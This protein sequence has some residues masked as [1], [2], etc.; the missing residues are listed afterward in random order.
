MRFKDLV[1]CSVE[2]LAFQTKAH[3]A[4]WG[5]GSESSWKFDQESG[6]LTWSF[7]QRVVMAPAG[8]VGTFNETEGSWLWS[9]ANSSISKT[10]KTAA[11]LAREHGKTNDFDSLIEPRYD[12]DVNEAW[13]LAAL[14]M[15]LSKHQGVYKIKEGIVHV[16][17]C[18]G[19]VRIERSQLE[20]DTPAK[21]RSV[22]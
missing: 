10:L 20:L 22:P 2:E 1:Q 7:P 3:T 6:L 5:L 15:H 14:T 13:E 18:F 16:F 17:L 11:N 19:N 21:A 4:M 12:C 8:I 9:W